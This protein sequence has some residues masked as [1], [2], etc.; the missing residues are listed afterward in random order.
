M[1]GEIRQKT[2]S[3]SRTPRVLHPAKEFE[4][5]AMQ[6]SISVEGL[7]KPRVV[8]ATMPPALA[9]PSS[10]LGLLIAFNAELRRSSKALKAP[11]QQGGDCIL[12]LST[13]PPLGVGAS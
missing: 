11:R 4:T 1:V 6:T 5:C 7:G 8:Q 10:P 12:Y 3:T 9:Q 2:P 13:P